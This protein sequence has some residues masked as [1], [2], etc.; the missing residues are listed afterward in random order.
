MFLFSLFPSVLSLLDENKERMYVFI[1]SGEKK[2]K[3]YKICIKHMCVK[4]SR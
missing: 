4:E 1:I 3:K 2:N